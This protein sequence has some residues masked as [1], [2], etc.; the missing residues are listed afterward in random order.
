MRAC[1]PRDAGSAG[2]D[3]IAR[4]RRIDL[5]AAVTL[6]AEIGDFHRFARARELMGFLGLVPS[7]YSSGSKRRQ[8]AITKT[9]NSHARRV[10]VEAAWNYRFPARVSRPLQA[11]QEGQPKIVRDIQRSTTISSLPWSCRSAVSRRAV[12]MLLVAYVLRPLSLHAHR[13][14]GVRVRSLHILFSQ[15]TVGSY[16]AGRGLPMFTPGANPNPLAPHVA[17]PACASIRHVEEVPK[18]C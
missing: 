2:R 14:S 7:E 4:A 3:A 16:Y 1:A 12:R 9:G 8:G 15:S 18:C 11:R 5:I 13:L 6:V 10:L 17:T